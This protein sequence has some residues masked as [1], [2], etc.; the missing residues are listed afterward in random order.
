MTEPSASHRIAEFEQ[1]VPRVVALL[2]LGPV[3]RTVN[4]GRA[5]SDQDAAYCRAS[6]QAKLA[7]A[8]R[9][10]LLGIAAANL[11]RKSTGSQSS[12]RR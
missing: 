12:T 7:W 3:L 10:V 11:R 1:V 2:E 8:D 5:R 4:Q 6:G 9:L